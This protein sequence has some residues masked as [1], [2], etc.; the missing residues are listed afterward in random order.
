MEKNR[1]IPKLFIAFSIL[2]FGAM[3]AVVGYNY[4]SLEYAGKYLG[5]SAP[6]STAFV[7]EV[8][9]LAAILVLIVLAKRFSNKI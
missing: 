6:A 2:I 3:C 7:L 8:P 4:A 1:V 5:A 9:F